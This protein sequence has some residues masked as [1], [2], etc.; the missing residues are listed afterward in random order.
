MKSLIVYSSQTGNTLK[1]AMAVYATLPG[2]K[3]MVAVDDAPEPEGY[4][5]IAVGFW[6]QAGKPDPKA[7]AYLQKIGTT[8]LFLF[9]THGA[10]AESAHAQDAM[11]YAQNLAPGA[12]ILGTFNCQGEVNPKVLLKI[13]NK[14]PKPPWI[15]DADA[16]KGHPDE[17][18]LG[19]LKDI[20]T[21]LAIEKLAGRMT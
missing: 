4:D 6:L 16:A 1:L 2:E 15:G 12:Q 11:K 9:A 7:A 20:V 14:N 3:E 19:R 17:E 5:C 13:R 10:A 8:P 18:D 21:S